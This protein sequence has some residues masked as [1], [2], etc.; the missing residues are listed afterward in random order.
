[1]ET[2]REMS[3]PIGTLHMCANE[4]GLTNLTLINNKQEDCISESGAS[5]I[6]EE[7]ER[8]IQAYFSGN[9]TQFDL[10]LD[11]SGLTPFQL[12]ALQA[13]SRIPFG[14]VITYGELAIMA[15]N[16]RGARAAGGAMAHNPFMLVV[17]CHRVVASDGSLHGYSAEG[18]IKTKQL[19]LEFEGLKFYNG[20][21]LNWK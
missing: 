8:Q 20:K 12:K 15:G 17:P 16:P 6:L 10:P 3:T 11:F 4:T 18:N 21:V 2:Y 5:A 14:E 1:M 13:C 9:L 19:L 7:A